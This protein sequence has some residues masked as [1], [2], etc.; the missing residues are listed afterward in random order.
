MHADDR[1]PFLFTGREEH[2]VPY[3][4][5][6]IDE[7][8]ETAEPIERVLHES[9]RALPVG[10]VVRVR[11]RNATERVDLVDNLLCR[12]RVGTGPGRRHTEVVHDDASTLAREGERV[13]ATDA[14]PGTCD[15]D[16]ASLADAGHGPYPTR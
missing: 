13:L 3:E 2:A 1:V 9:A 7:D 15:D 14:A 5:G 10:D 16:D 4:T 8:V 6:V 11:D 12:T